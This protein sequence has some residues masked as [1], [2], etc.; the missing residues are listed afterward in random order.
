M[1]P[2][3]GA[4]VADRARDDADIEDLVRIGSCVRIDVRRVRRV[5]VLAGPGPGSLLGD[6]DR[7]AVADAVLDVGP[8]DGS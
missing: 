3:A 5:E 4:R 8:L 7:E 1:H 6:R 2:L